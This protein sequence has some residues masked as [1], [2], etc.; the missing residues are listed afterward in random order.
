MERCT[1]GPTTAWRFSGFS[2]AV[3]SALGDLWQVQRRRTKL[4]SF[5]LSLQDDLTGPCP[6][7]RLFLE[8][9]IASL[10]DLCGFCDFPAYPR[11]F[12]MEV[13]PPI[14]V[15]ALELRV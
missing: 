14:R 9:G 10:S 5:G 3:S 2:E 7:S 1:W 15:L 11:A 12:R 6:R 4:Q 13:P 8:T